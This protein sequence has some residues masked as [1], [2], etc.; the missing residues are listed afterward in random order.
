LAGH[1]RRP[2]VVGQTGLSAMA[3]IRKLRGRW[4]AHTPTAPACARPWRPSRAACRKTMSRLHE[5][6]TWRHP[7]MGG[8]TVAIS[9]CFDR[10]YVFLLNNRVNFFS[11][12]RP[13]IRLWRPVWLPYS[14]PIATRSAENDAFEKFLSEVRAFDR[15]RYCDSAAIRSRSLTDRISH[16][17]IMMPPSLIDIAL[18]QPRPGRNFPARIAIFDWVPRERRSPS[19]VRKR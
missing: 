16:M 14:H 15:R 10:E 1:R 5:M 9:Y 6:S 17:L 8:L 12:A 2:V 13:K 3:T 4:Q 18:S 11:A 19:S 7:E